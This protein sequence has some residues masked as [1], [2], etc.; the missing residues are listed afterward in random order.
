MS[1]EVPNYL[2]MSDE[3]LLNLEA[4]SFANSD[5]TPADPQP[6][7]STG[8]EAQPADASASSE[9]EAEAAR[10]TETELDPDE[11]PEATDPAAQAPVEGA[12][13]EKPAAADPTPAEQPAAADPAPTE[14]PIDYKA[15]YERLMGEFKANGK[16]VQP[17][18]VED[19]IA[20]MQMGAN[21]HKKM[22]SMKPNLK[23]LKLLENNGLLDEDKLS[24]LIDLDKKNPDAISKLVKD[25]GID[26][27]DMDVA[28]GDG[29]KPQKHVVDERELAL[30]EVLDSIQHTPTYQ[31]TLEVVSKVW[32][33]SSKQYAVENPQLFQVINDHM[34]SGVYDLIVSEV[35][36]ER[37]FGRLTNV[38]D[39]E[40]YRQV[41][42]AIQARNG[43]AH[44]FQSKPTPSA[45]AG[46]PQVPAAAATVAT[47]PK[48]DAEDPALRERRKAASPTKAASPAPAT[49][50]FNPLALSDDD[51]IKLTQP[52]F[53]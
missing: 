48:A 26:P 4:P 10:S 18:S 13:A 50:D 6:E 51:F 28:K 2:D 41:G 22:A 11:V 29:Y 45:P 3:D 25:S 35:E 12:A 46:Q 9:A 52:R 39:L 53:R 5:P 7:P 34:A 20:L 17:R 15:A 30:D 19:A 16:V 1:T 47:P 14:Q 43:F 27:L 49:Q 44:L 8:N 24:F 23:I 36:R 40:A 21:Y 31:K 42:D 38:S 33:A 37:T 32:D